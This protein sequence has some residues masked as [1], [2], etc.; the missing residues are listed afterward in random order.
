VG[1]VLAT[2]EKQALAV[3]VESLLQQGEP[4]AALKLLESVRRDALSGEDI[5]LLQEVLAGTRVVYAHAD[6]RRRNEAGRIA[7]AAQ[8]NIRFIEQK[9]TLAGGSDWFDSFVLPAARLV[10]G[11]DDAAGRGGG[12]LGVRFPKYAGRVWLTWVALTVLVVVPI[13]ALTG[14]LMPVLEYGVFP[15]LEP[16]PANWDSPQ[17]LVKGVPIGV[18]IVVATWTA[19]YFEKVNSRYRDRVVGSTG[20]KPPGF[21]LAVTALVFAVVGGSTGG[22]AFLPVAVVVAAVAWWRISATG[23]RYARGSATAATTFASVAV[24]VAV[25]VGSVA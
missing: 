2:D 13:G 8:Q 3:R 21:G 6:Q 10:A 22:W 11:S 5:A 4:K 16:P 18:W 14:I 15:R 9:Q 24:A 12:R 7:N 1:A 17:E 20:S 23:T 19:I 25:V